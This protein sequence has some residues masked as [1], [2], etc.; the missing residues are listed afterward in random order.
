M[1]T[2]EGR[3]VFSSTPNPM[4]MPNE[5]GPRKQTKFGD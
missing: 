1:K 5:R 2:T 4:A 3:Q